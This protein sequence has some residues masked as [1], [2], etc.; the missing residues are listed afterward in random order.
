MKLLLTLAL[1]NLVYTTAAAATPTGKIPSE[2]RFTHPG[3]MPR[4][5]PKESQEMFPRPLPPWQ[6]D[7]CPT[8]PKFPTPRPH[9]LPYPEPTF[10]ERGT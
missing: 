5:D 7:P 9:P 6:L 8:R 2:E 1:A 10:P 4:I 3:L